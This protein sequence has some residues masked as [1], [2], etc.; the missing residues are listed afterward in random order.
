MKAVVYGGAVA[1]L[2]G[3]IFGAGM[4]APVSAGDLPQPQLQQISYPV[5][6]VSQED[7][8]P[9]YV[10]AAAYAPADWASDQ[11]RLWRTAYAAPA[12]QADDPA[13]LTPPADLHADDPGLNANPEASE[14]APRADPTLPYAAGMTTR[15]NSTP[16]QPQARPASSWPNKR[17][18]AKQQVFNGSDGFEHLR[19]AEAAA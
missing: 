2:A 15:S 6:T 11:P 16:E 5:D 10:V 7:F 18:D 1:A 4:K 3:L 12:P 13:E 14:P 17:G 8:R 19:P 9:D